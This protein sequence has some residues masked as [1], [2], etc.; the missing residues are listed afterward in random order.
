MKVAKK[1]SG[2]ANRRR[3]IHAPPRA[4]VLAL[5]AGQC[6]PLH[7]LKPQRSTEYDMPGEFNNESSNGS[8]RFF[9]SA[10]PEGL[11][12]VIADPGCAPYQILGYRLAGDV[13]HQA[14]P[15]T[16]LPAG[17]FDTDPSKRQ[18]ALAALG[19]TQNESIDTHVVAEL[20]ELKEILLA[21]TEA[22]HGSTKRAGSG[23]RR[24]DA[25]DET[26]AEILSRMWRTA[27]GKRQLKAAG[28]AEGIS[29]LIGKSETAVKEAGIIWD[30]KIKPALSGARYATRIEREE[31]RRKGRS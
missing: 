22:Q 25:A 20:R 21:S 1:V 15:P 3:Y 19:T 8:A 18:E 28:S 12:L 2:H 26:T 13:C 31:R 30:E 23:N 9:P 4:R 11:D 17:L 16:K 5:R 6:D 29:Q 24:S 10:M 27:D 14:W 7:L